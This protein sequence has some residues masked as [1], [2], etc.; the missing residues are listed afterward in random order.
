M[1]YYLNN[2]K[3]LNLFE[4]ETKSQYFVDKSDIISEL[5]PLVETGKKS[6]CIT[7]PR[8]F[9]KSVMA[10]LVGAF[11][12]KGADASKI[13]QP[14]RISE[15]PRCADHLHQ[16]DLIYIDFSKVPLSGK[17]IGHYIESISKR[18]RSDLRKTFSNI[19][20]SECENVVDDFNEVCDK[21]GKKFIFVFDEWDYIFHKDNVSNIDKK[22][23]NNFLAFLTKDQP[24]ISLVYMTGIL[25][26]AKYSSGSS[27]NHFSE[28]TM[29]TQPK[30][31]QYFGF[32]DEEVDVLYAKYLSTHSEPQFS[33]EDLR[34]WYDGYYA[35][36]GKRMY[37]P[38]SV[39]RALSDNM[40][41]NYWTRSGPFTEV[42]EYIKDH[43]LDGLNE[44]IASMVAGEPVPIRL[45]EDAAAEKQFKTVDQILSAMVVYGFL[46]YHIDESGQ[47]VVSIPNKELM[48]E[49]ALTLEQSKELGYIHLLAA[50]SKSLLKA[51]LDGDTDTIAKILEEAH[52]AE[53]DIKKFNSEA[54]LSI[55]V[56]IAYLA[57]RD[58]YDIQ[59]E[60]RGGVGYADFV[61]Y[62]KK[63]KSADCIILELKKDDTPEEA[64]R[65][66]KT[67]Q[68]AL[69]F[70]GKFGEKSPYTG[71]IVAYGISYNSKTGKHCCK[72]EVLEERAD[73]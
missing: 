53:V 55:T 12:S 52:L 20:Y 41:S 11:F 42:A 39:V 13:F 19:D 36:D 27:L 17:G 49:F 3:P 58:I 47:G 23:Y 22:E 56:Q 35:L 30:Y 16:H 24:Y 4:P 18:L 34:Y 1:G 44:A 60:E 45:T 14:L 71:R 43:A 32:T 37:N 61:F 6:I 70:K 31:S 63:D 73:K 33:R 64:I 10:S 7:R 40:L 2:K 25:P 57:A 62:P 59:L 50:R 65:Q 38:R 46:N 8:R 67:K 69:C 15:H 9:G 5:I 48:D 28:Y 54:G 21:T 72:R 68:Y 26:I 29:G 51:T 66:I